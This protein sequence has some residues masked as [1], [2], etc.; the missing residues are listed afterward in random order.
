[1]GLKSLFERG[2]LWSHF[3]PINHKLSLLDVCINYTQPHHFLGLYSKVTD[4]RSSNKA[5]LM[6]HPAL[7]NLVRTGPNYRIQLW[8]A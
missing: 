2:M 5:E 3:R 7:Q 8:F 6:Y 1:M 4:E